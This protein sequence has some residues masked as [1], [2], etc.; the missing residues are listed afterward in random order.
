MTAGIKLKSLKVQIRTITL[1]FVTV[2]Q[3]IYG[4]IAIAIDLFRLLITDHVTIPRSVFF[5]PKLGI[6]L[7]ACSLLDEHEKGSNLL[8]IVTSSVFGKKSTCQISVMN[9]SD[10]KVYLYLI[11]INVASLLKYLDIA[12]LRLFSNN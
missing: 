8:S 11:G 2:G 4:F 3:V 10:W 1:K 7:L 6:F 5:F 12:P 9:I